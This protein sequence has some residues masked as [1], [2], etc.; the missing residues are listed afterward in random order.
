MI[1]YCTEQYKII[2]SIVTHFN[3]KYNNLIE[4]V[5]NYKY[6]FVKRSIFIE[7]L[8]SVSN[9]KPAVQNEF[10]NILNKSNE[11]TN[12]I[13]VLFRTIKP[14]TTLGEKGVEQSHI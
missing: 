12:K 14:I 10:E 7:I 3:S 13:D 11:L 5:S 9:D 1:S 6:N 4:Y 8:K 2:K